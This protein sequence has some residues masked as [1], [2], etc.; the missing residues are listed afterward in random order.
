MRKLFCRFFMVLMFFYFHDFVSAEIPTLILPASGAVLDNGCS[1]FSDKIEWDFDW[2]DV[3]GAT[4]YHLYVIGGHATIPLINNSSL[5][6]SDYHHENSG[7]IINDNIYN[8]K[9]KVRAYLNGSWNNWSEERKFDVEPLN[10]DCTSD[11]IK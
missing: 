10:T 8:W 2:S 1:D 6:T 11:I 4:Q 5:S 7:Y 9:W 3:I